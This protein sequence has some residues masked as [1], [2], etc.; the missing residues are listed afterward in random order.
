ME[1]ELDVEKAKCVMLRKEL[2]RADDDDVQATAAGDDDDSKR[3]QH[4]QLAELQVRLTRL[5]SP[6]SSHSYVLHINVLL[7]L[8]YYYYC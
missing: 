4:V 6:S 8:Y 1:C 3:Y 5:T 7:L 2:M